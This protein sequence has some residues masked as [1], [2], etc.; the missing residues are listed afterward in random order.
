MFP[1]PLGPVLET[2]FLYHPPLLSDPSLPP[3]LPPGRS[4][5]SKRTLV[6]WIYVRNHWQGRSEISFFLSVSFPLF[7]CSRA[8]WGRDSTR[9]SWTLV[10]YTLAGQGFY[11]SRDGRSWNASAL[12]GIKLA[13]NATDGRTNEPHVVTVRVLLIHIARLDLTQHDVILSILILRGCVVVKALCYKP[14]GRGLD[15]RW[16]QFLNLPNLSCSIRP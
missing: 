6:Y 4:S 5:G 15:T 7:S 14:G 16:G 11:F 8:P 13:I 12:S 3:P 2:S 10:Q 9:V 1:D